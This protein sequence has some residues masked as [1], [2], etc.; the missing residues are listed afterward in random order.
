MQYKIK[1]N[2]YP[3]HSHP[4]RAGGGGAQGGVGGVGI[5]ISFDFVLYYSVFFYTLSKPLLKLP[6]L[7]FLSIYGTWGLELISLPAS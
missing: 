1:R 4:T 3:H 5:C 7:G 2:T 6:G